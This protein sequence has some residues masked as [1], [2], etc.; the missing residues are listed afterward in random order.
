MWGLT[1]DKTHVAFFSQQEVVKLLENS[2]FG[3]VKVRG[4]PIF[5]YDRKPFIRWGRNKRRWWILKLIDGFV[6]LIPYFNQFGA[7]QVFLFRKI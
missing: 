5:R 6:N 4:G 1:I 7:I 3:L 2:G